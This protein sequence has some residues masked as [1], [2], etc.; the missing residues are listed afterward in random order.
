MLFC[1]SVVD[2]DIWIYIHKNRREYFQRFFLK[3]QI[4]SY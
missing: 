2:I 1:Y 4:E 3:F